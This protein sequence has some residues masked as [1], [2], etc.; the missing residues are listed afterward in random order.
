VGRSQEKDDDTI[1][2]SGGKIFTFGSYRLNVHAPNTDIDALCVAPRH[3]DRE[4]HFFGGEPKSQKEKEGREKYPYSSLPKLLSDNPLVKN[5]NCVTEAF[6]PRIGMEFDGIDIDLVFARVEAKEV[7]EDLQNLLND[8]IL[9]NCDEKSVRSL[10]GSRVADI[11]L[12]KVP[13]KEKFSTTLRCIKLWAKNRGIYSN[14]LGYF[15]GVSWM[16][17]VAFICM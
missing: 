12:E 4:I 8:S 9:K 10:N 16:I 17:L 1:H 7:G 11:V 6:V 2:N 13:D 15:G 5:L 14:V 3:V